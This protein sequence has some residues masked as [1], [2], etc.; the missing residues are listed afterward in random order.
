M[1]TTT[2]QD[3]L[4]LRVSRVVA[5]EGQR[6]AERCEREPGPSRSKPTRREQDLRLW[7]MTF[8][9]ALGLQLGEEPDADLDTAAEDALDAAR[10]AYMR[11]AP[12]IAPRPPFLP[13]VDALLVAYR[14]V[15]SDVESAL[16]DSTVGR[17]FLEKMH[18][19][20]EVIGMPEPPVER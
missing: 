7:G 8:G 3:S 20:I 16:M 10:A 15:E 5:E 1:S 17:D 18:D 12:P 9:I 6:A 2:T 19:L 4:A 11:W 13:A 14:R